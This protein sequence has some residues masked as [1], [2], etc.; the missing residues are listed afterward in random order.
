MTPEQAKTLDDIAWTVGQ[1][2]GQTDNI[3]P[4]LMKP[5]DDTAWLLSNSVLELLKEISAKLDRLGG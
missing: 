5:V 3:N 2:K 1:I 4:R